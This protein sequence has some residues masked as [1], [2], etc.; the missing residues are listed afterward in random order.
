MP[1]ARDKD[2][3]NMQCWE[4]CNGERR[5][6]TNDANMF[7]LVRKS[8]RRHRQTR[9]ETEIETDADRETETEAETET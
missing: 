6:T 3:T 9:T 5:D 1:Q 2:G 4:C 7:T 8:G